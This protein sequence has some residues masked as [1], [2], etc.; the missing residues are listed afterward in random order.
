MNKSELINSLS[1]ETMFNKKDISRVL[2]SLTRIIERTLK[3]G[4]KVSITG[5]GSFWLSFRPARIGINPTNK[6]KITLKEVHVPRFK[7]GKNLRE[8]VRTVK[9][10]SAY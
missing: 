9:S 7:A 4:E 5:F 10:R 3:K 8:A 6:Q 1:E 2:D